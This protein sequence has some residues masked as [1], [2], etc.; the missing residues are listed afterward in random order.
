MKCRSPKPP[1]IRVYREL[2]DD[3]A[4]EYERET[5][6]HRVRLLFLS[7]PDEREQIFSEM[8]RN[9]IAWERRERQSSDM[10]NAQRALTAHILSGGEFAYKGVKLCKYPWRA[11]ETA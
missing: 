9:G 4:A 6:S 10:S 11:E 5:V 1:L 3:D 7:F 2:T 8:V